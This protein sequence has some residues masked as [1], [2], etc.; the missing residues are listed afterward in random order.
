[1]AETPDRDRLKLPAA[2][3]KDLRRKEVDI[4]QVRRELQHLKKLGLETKM[5]EEKLDWA[6]EVR[7]TLLKEFT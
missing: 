5:L 2:V 1:M 3:V 6:E 4:V 7:K